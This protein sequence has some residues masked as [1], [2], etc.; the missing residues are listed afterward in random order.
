M[1]CHRLILKLEA[2]L[3]SSPAVFSLAAKQAYL[4]PLAN[5]VYGLISWCL[6][7]MW[8][9]QLFWATSCYSVRRLPCWWMMISPLTK[10]CN[11]RYDFACWKALSIKLPSCLF[12]RFCLFWKSLQS[13]ACLGTNRTGTFPISCQSSW[14]IYLRDKDP[15]QVSSCDAM[16]HS[17]LS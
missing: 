4:L 8:K 11:S 10:W 14:E 13:W 2:L 16:Q 17:A 9:L 6:H 5:F 1:R 3:G 15:D 7:C 12:C